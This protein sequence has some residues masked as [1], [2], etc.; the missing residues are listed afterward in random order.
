ST[1]LD[2]VVRRDILNA[3]VRTVAD[4]GRT[5]LF[6]SHLLDEVEQMSDQVIMINAGRVV[7]QGDL[8]TI[9]QQHQRLVVRFSS[10]REALPRID[11][12]LSAERQHDHWVLVCGEPTDQLQAVLTAA[13]GDIIQ[14]RCASLQETFIARAGR[15]SES[16]PEVTA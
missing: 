15:K 7:L 6:S 5:V 16:S 11:G 10:P 2:P 8:D 1:G 13:G 9:R 4:E 14:V 3:I 12:V